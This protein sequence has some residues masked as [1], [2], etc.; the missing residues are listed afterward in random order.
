MSL[1][2]TPGSSAQSKLIAAAVSQTLQQNS[3]AALATLIEAPTHVGSKLLV[4]ELGDTPSPVGSL[5][6]E[7]LDYAAIAQAQ[8]F[9][10]SRADLIGAKRRFCLSA[11]KPSHAW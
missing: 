9:L 11:F 7:A 1:S 10:E 3:T 8:K 6:S 5:G 4:R 2:E